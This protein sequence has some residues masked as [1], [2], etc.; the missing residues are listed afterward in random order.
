[1]VAEVWAWLPRVHE[2]SLLFVKHV[3]NPSSTYHTTW[4]CECYTY[5]LLRV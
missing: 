5:A 4:V 3:L 2:L 1:M